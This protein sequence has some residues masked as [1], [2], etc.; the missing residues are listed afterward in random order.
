V[1]SRPWA[2]TLASAARD[3]KVS[4]ALA[5]QRSTSLDRPSLKKGMIARRIVM[6]GEAKWVLKNPDT[7]LF[8]DIQEVT[9]A[10]LE[11]F[12]GTLTRD[13]IVDEYNRRYPGAPID[14]SV[15]LELEDQARKTDLLELSTIDRN[16]YLLNKMK[17]ARKRKAEEKAEGFNIFFMVFKVMDPNRF[18]DRSSKY[19]QWIWSPPFVA[20]SLV[21]FALTVGVF[22]THF[23]QLWR[24][25][26]ELFALTS[27][28]FMDIVQLIVIVMI[29]LGLHELGHAY[30][31]KRYGG[32]VH[33]MGIALLYFTPAL[34][35]DAADQYMFPNKWH[36]L[37]VQL[38]GVYVE[39]LICAVGTGLWVVTYPDTFLHDAAYKTMLY[40]GIS[41]FFFNINPLVKVDGYNALASVLEMPELREDS[42]R[43]LGQL[44]Q[45][46]VLRLPV[47]VPFV[48]RR[49]RRIYFTYAIP[50][51]AYIVFLMDFITRFFGN[52]YGK[53]FPLLAPALLV[54]TVFRLFRKRIRLFLR[55][56]RMVYLDK[57]EFL[58]SSR[59]RPY[60]LTA[61]ILF[62]LV[63]VAPWSRRVIRADVSLA[64]VSTLQV[65]APGD[66]TV[67]QVLVH[68]SDAVQSGQPLMAMSSPTADAR[69]QELTAQREGFAKE[70]SRGAS[71]DDSMTSFRAEEHRVATDAGLV[72][73]VHLRSA[74]EI[75][76]PEAGRVLT[77]DTT[78]LQGR[79][80]RRGDILLAVGDCRRIRAEIPIT[81]RLV[82]TVQNGSDVSLRLHAR[83]FE[84]FRGRV[85]SIAAASSGYSATLPGARK[86]LF[87]PQMP[88][89]FVA[90]AEFENTSG[91][92]IPGMSGEATIHLKRGSLL[93][94]S[95]TVLKHWVQTIVW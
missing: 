53:Y 87:P 91:A 20:V 8:H 7:G 66:G 79:F 82:S 1:S 23:G 24:E 31:V 19:V 69:V 75:R 18:L 39:S 49:M 6:L 85:V 37:W 51:L 40:T 44:F 50:A 71:E 22:V 47:E 76:S 94:R 56:S 73:A 29:I 41:T 74:F 65:Q 28:G 9:W 26:F 60:L 21:A 64:P 3:A 70:A 62:V 81:E 12:D 32:E 54:L 30:V 78:S 14:V 92:L 46:H 77:P 58:M 55:I 10:L 80:F 59:V 90:T 33:D 72:R 27:K 45:R 68:E 84:S 86:G 5:S 11:L 43:Y 42:F 25:T 57:K 48:S 38:A 35:T 63:L 13:E 89:R 52:L 17:N 4:E 67:D 34:Y 93:G 36:R 15:V 16:F 83:P 95:A 2:R 61:A 88:E